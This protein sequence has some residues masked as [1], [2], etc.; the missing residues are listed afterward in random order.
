M[1]RSSSPAARLKVA[2]K[3][4][5][6]DFVQLCRM[7]WWR[8]CRRPQTNPKL[9]CSQGKLSSPARVGFKEKR[10]LDHSTAQKAWGEK[11]V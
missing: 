9:Q 1:D 7:E 6:H 2:V 4:L 10:G 3:S 8:Y 11:C 5:R